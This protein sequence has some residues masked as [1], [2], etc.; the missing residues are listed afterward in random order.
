MLPEDSFISLKKYLD[1]KEILS[2]QEQ[3]SSQKMIDDFREESIEQ[4]NEIISKQ[5]YLDKGQMKF[6]ED[7]NLLMKDL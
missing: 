7:S 5:N 2:D 1:E 6:E 3:D 4:T